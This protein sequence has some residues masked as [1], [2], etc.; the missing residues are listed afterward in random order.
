VWSLQQSMQG[1]DAPKANPVKQALGST[2]ATQA[3]QPKSANWKEEKKRLEREV[4]L[5]DKMINDCEAEMARLQKETEELNIT[6]S[7][8]SAPDLGLVKKMSENGK[9]IQELEE[10][11]LNLS[12]E[13]EQY[14]KEVAAML[15]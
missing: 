13:R 6:L 9:R 7:N 8:A 15:E 12:E 1:E 10:A 2:A 11:W 5:R 4:R 14:R 3:Q